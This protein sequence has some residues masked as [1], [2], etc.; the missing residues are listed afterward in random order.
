MKHTHHN[1]KA[2]T[3]AML[4]CAVALA[5]GLSACRGDRTQEPPRQFFPDLDDAPKWNPQTHSEFFADGRT[6]RQPPAHAVAFGRQAIVPGEEWGGEFAQQR[7]D[8]LKENPGYY[9]GKEGDKYLEK[10]PIAF[11]EA[12]LLRGKERFGIYCAVCHGHEGDGQ[13]MVG[14][15]WATPVP[16]FHDP[17]YTDV[18]QVQGLDGYLFHTARNGVPAG[19]AENPDWANVKMPGYRHALSVEDTWRVVAYIRALQHSR[20]GTIDNVP[21]G[22]R[23]AVREQMKSADAA[24]KAAAD[25][26]ATPAPA[27]A[28]PA[29]AT[30]G[31]K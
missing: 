9:S 13:G 3:R 18:K 31:G 17:K 21:E 28:P 23:D 10:A 4:A 27:P 24:A 7:A 8:L 19:T 2:G 26:A 30:G 15:Q 22:H 14:K 5:A 20:A 25:A 1:T 29:P 12:D 11:T 6:M 16:A